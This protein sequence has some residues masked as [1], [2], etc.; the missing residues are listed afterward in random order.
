MTAGV[1]RGRRRSRS[2]KLAQ[3]RPKAFRPDLAVSLDNLGLRQS[4]LGQREAALASTQEALDAIW[5]LFLRLPASFE[6]H[7]G[8]H[9]GNLRKCLKALGRPPPPWLLE[10]EATFAAMR[11]SGA[12]SAG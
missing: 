10:R 4:E 1:R 3:A 6:R 5:P 7:T 11:S 12:G 9:L 8:M 2:I